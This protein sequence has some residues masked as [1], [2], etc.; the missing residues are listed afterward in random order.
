[1]FFLKNVKKILSS[2]GRVTGHKTE[3]RLITCNVGTS[4]LLKERQWKIWDLKLCFSHFI[5]CIAVAVSHYY[6]KPI[7]SLISQLHQYVT[8]TLQYITYLFSKDRRCFCR[9]PKKSIAIMMTWFAQFWFAGS[10]ALL[11]F[12]FWPGLQR[13][14]AGNFWL[15]AGGWC[16]IH[17]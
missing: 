14:S 13:S 15:W 7:K 6:Y 12:E 2:S 10:R 9:P 3:S 17:F 1:M 5:D 11:Q 8:T 4:K 16:R